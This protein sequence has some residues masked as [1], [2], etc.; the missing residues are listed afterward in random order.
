[1][2]LHVQGSV[3]NKRRYDHQQETKRATGDNKGREERQG[4]VVSNRP[5]RTTI[6]LIVF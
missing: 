6:D 2:L 4:Y 5:F 3:T 1:L